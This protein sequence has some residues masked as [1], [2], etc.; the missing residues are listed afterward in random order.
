MRTAPLP[1]LNCSSSS[2][3]TTAATTSGQSTTPSG[4]TSP[5]P[6]NL[7]TISRGLS[8][9][10]FY[11]AVP[12]FIVRFLE[13]DTNTKLVAKPQLRGAEGSKLTLK[14]PKRRRR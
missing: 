7:N 2:R 9:A 6:F 8:A 1:A 3:T 10:D 11:F 14:L 4:I 13:S 12:T 5:P